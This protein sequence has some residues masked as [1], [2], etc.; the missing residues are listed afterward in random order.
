MNV[1]GTR[2]WCFLAVAAA[3]TTWSGGVKA[4]FCGDADCGP[5]GACDPVSIL[6]RCLCDPGTVSVQTYLADGS[7][8][9][10]CVPLAAPPSE[11]A[12]EPFA[13]GPHGVCTAEF[14]SP[15][16]G[17]G[18]RCVC[19]PGFE[20]DGDGGCQDDPLDD[21]EQVCAEAACG[22]GA[23][24]MALPDA[25]TCR[26]A[27]GGS[28]ILG[29]GANGGFGPVC[30][31]PPNLDL[32]CGPDACGPRGECVLSQAIFCDCEDGYEARELQG[33]DGK[34]HPYCVGPDGKVPVDGAADA[35]A[36][37][38]DAGVHPVRPA[39]PQTSSCAVATGATLASGVHFPR[40]PWKNGGLWI[41]F[42]LALACSYRRC[43]RN[44][45]RSKPC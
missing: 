14:T 44:R 15:D 17:T 4:A 1:A 45:G 8:G 42:V 10:Y 19:D 33:P 36:V 29:S 13:C 23:T 30:T 40:A 7:L 25:V 26:C 32:A 21:A 2:H 31:Y 43:A 6:S 11:L 39:K 24:C 27:P 37:A 22:D 3:C 41:L 28:V 18:A 35:G 12:C 16:G 34:L 20:P 5:S 9:A 38:E